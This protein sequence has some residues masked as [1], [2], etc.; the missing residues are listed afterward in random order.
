[1][2]LA[3][4]QFYSADPEKQTLH[5]RVRPSDEQIEN[6][7]EY[8]NDLADYL[9]PDLKD[10]SGYPVTSW[11]QGSYKFATQVR[12]PNLEEEFDIDLGVY[13]AWKGDP[14]D[15]GL[16]A[17]DLKEMVQDS[18][19]AYANDPDTDALRVTDPKE[20]CSRIVVDGS[21]HID[22]PA[23]HEDGEQRTLASKSDGFVESDP[24]AIWEWWLSTFEES[25]RPRARRIVRYLKMW[26][27]L[28][29]NPKVES[30]PSSILLTILV[31]YSYDKVDLTKVSG[32][33]E[34][35]EAIVSHMIDI[36]EAD[37][38]VENP[39]NPDE[40][41]NRLGD[42][43][44]NF[45]EKLRALRDIS[46]AANQAAEAVTASEKWTEA[47]GHFFPFPDEQVGKDTVQKAGGAVVTT[48]TPEIEIT[49]KLPTGRTY[50]SINSAVAVPKG[51]V[52]DFDVINAHAAPAN[53]LIKWVVRNEGQVAEDKNDLGHFA[54]FGSS[55]GGEQA[56]Y[57]GRH[58]MD[59]T[60]IK[61]GQVVGM[62]RVPVSILDNSLR[63]RSKRL[64]KR[65]AR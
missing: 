16:S 46:H 32:D 21:F 36:L 9:K 34:L 55:H 26:A 43:F 23:Y 56:D 44:P 31:A 2:G 52:L 51:S 14:D 41:L 8:W 53:S 62:R 61:N 47:F 39:V 54:A 63:N 28:K 45:M 29:F 22:V 5:K 20:F 49:I 64:F 13:F 7:K 42:E 11:I 24:V 10:R 50:K 15:G 40:D 57:K 58:F 33:D 19:S 27:A 65:K 38:K 3:S 1:M 25:E 17:T 18:L 60:V 37:E 59:V 6:Q 35:L 4:G 30:R 12:P 48:F